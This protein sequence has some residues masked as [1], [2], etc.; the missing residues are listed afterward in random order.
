MIFAGE[1]KFYDRPVDIR[2]YSA[3]L[4][5]CKTISE[6]NGY[7]MIY[8]LFSKSGFDERVNELAEN[9]HNIILINGE[10]TLLQK[11]I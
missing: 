7:R 8:G 4:E 5:K 1:C 6:F 9:S 11:Q 2:V 3:L 10:Q